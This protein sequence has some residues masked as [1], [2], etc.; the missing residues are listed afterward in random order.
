[1][2]KTL[3]YLQIILVI[4]SLC[5]LVGCNNEKKYAT[6]TSDVISKDNDYVDIDSSTL[7]RVE[8]IG[9]IPVS[10]DS[11]RDILQKTG[12]FEFKEI[13]FENGVSDYNFGLDKNGGND[14]TAHLSFQVLPGMSTEIISYNF[15]KATVMSDQSED[16]RWG[17]D[18]LLRIFE[19]ELTDETW[20][21]ILEVA[22]SSEKVG[23]LGVDHKG[24][25]NEHAGI[26]L[27]YADLGDN[28]Q[29]DIRPY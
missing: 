13:H 5:C 9:R 19:T 12:R 1:M 21:D 3:V 2:K 11:I 29:I 15:S 8:A 20:E 16:I 6:K 14:C 22:E 10:T 17:L 23:A 4:Y 18:T 26:R 28:M 25:E 24:Y 27:I 7:I